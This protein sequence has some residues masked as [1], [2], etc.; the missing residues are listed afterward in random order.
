MYEG[1]AL[2]YDMFMDN[3]P[4][5]LWA[6]YLE[7][8]LH[9]YGVGDG[10]LLELGCGTG[11]MTK[12]MREKG[13]DMIGIDLSEDMLEIA[14][15]K[16]P[17]D[18]LFLRQDMRDMELYGTVAAMFC[19]CDGIN[20]LLEPQDLQEVFVKAN[21]YLDSG[22]VFIFDMKT[23]Y[24]YRE[25]LGDRV[26]A[27]NREDASFLWENAFHADTGLNEYMLTVYRQQETGDLFSRCDELHCQRAYAPEA[28][29]RIIEDAGMEFVAVYDAL[30][31]QA[32]RR[33]SERLY[34]IAREK[35]QEGKYYNA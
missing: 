34:F 12:R 26:I 21:N 11:S 18:V 32:P 1:F 19:V 29:R 7:D 9:E 31:R 23:E 25:V 2:S 17:A 35:Y 15:E 3:I 27:E 22:G 13:Y 33:E 28:I 14:R 16:C 8:L 4:Y 30:T 5:D 10:L 24:F 20:Y 6:D